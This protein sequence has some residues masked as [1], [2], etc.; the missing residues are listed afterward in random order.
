MVWDSK[1]QAQSTG[2]VRVGASKLG[3]SSPL[4]VPI[5]FT[6]IPHCAGQKEALSSSRITLLLALGFS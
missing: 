6:A 4:N 3:L 5:M 1:A 2:F